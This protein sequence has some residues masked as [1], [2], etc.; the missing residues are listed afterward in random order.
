MGSLEQRTPLVVL[1][2]PELICTVSL[3]VCCS[4]QLRGI[5]VEGECRSN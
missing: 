3:R 4:M 1:Q 5:A 2:V